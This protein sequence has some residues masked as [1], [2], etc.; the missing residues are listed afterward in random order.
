MRRWP[1]QEGGGADGYA[2]FSSLSF[3]FCTTTCQVDRERSARVCAK[4]SNWRRKCRSAVYVCER[5]VCVDTADKSIAFSLFREV[6][7]GK[8]RSV[9]AVCGKRLEVLWWSFLKGEVRLERWRQLLKLGLLDEGEENGS[10]EGPEVLSF[11]QAKVVTMSNWP[12]EGKFKT[13]SCSA[14]D[15]GGGRIPRTCTSDRWANLSNWP[16]TIAATYVT[17]NLSIWPRR[18]S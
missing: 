11:L 15:G 9:E 16:E 6:F 17:K 14:E 18:N 4:R 5:C 13:R 7:V 1:R 3:L 12:R 2:S 10:A 8:E